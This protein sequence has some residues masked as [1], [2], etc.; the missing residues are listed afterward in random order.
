MQV[1]QPSANLPLDTQGL[2]ALANLYHA[3][4]LGLQLMVSTRLGEKVMEQWMFRLFRRQHEEKFLSSFSKLG[5]DHLPPAVACA[6]YH[7]LSNGMGGVPVEYIYESAT[8]AWVRFRYP[9]WMYAGP[10]IC[11]VTDAVS[12]GFLQGWYGHN[13][14]SLKNPRLGFVCVS[15]DMTGE[16]GLCGYFQEFDHDL[17]ANERLSYARQER[18]PAFKSADQPQAPS[19]QWDEARLL[20]AQRNYPMEYLRN[21]L[22]E[23]AGVIGPEEAQRHGE[24][25]ARLIG[26]QYA[27]ETSELLQMS[28][29]EF[30]SPEEDL[31][32]SAMLLARLFRAM[33]DQVEVKA[34][35]QGSAGVVLLHSG[36]R[37]VRGLDEAE[38]A[39]VLSCWGELWSGFLSADRRLKS[40]EV[41][42]DGEGLRWLVNT[43]P[44]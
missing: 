15:E 14:V 6:Q 39:L 23:L 41:Y 11:G 40:L 27:R 36:L 1:K 30:A 9:R 42:L 37:I 16:F 10:T 17:A 38:M 4:F 21:G 3:Y 29:D 5:L 32:R 20:R 18:P 35:D 44:S 2:A 22:V 31:A 26:L 24:L 7:K 43:N 12:R 19:G 28:E 25:A 33:D 34:D 8:K 13:G